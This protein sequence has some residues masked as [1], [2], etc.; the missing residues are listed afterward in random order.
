MV[1]SD[2]GGRAG[3]W[4]ELADRASP[5]TP[6]LRSWWLLHLQES[7]PLFVLVLDGDVL[8]GGVALRADRWLGARRLRMLGSGVLCGDHL[9][10]VHAAGQ[11]AVVVHHLGAWLAA[12]GPVLLD[13]A[14]L[15]ED[16][17]MAEAAGARSRP[18][19]VAP[20]GEV[21]GDLRG[22]YLAT[23]SRNLRR[24]AGR[25]KRR[26]E[27][28]GFVPET[29]APARRAETMADFERLHRD[30]ADRAPLLAER[31]ALERC[32]AAG[33]DAG[34]VRLDVLRRGAEAPVAVSIGFWVGGRLS[35]YQVA[36]SLAPEH[37][38]AGTVLILHVIEDAVRAGAVEIDLLR[39]AEVYKTRLVDDVRTL[40]RVR[41]ARGALPRLLL[42]LLTAAS[43]TRRRLVSA[44]R[45]APDHDAP[46]A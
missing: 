7:T 40:H 39:G 10:A 8:I 21:P 42:T 14:G 11:R 15:V 25:A 38:E 34:E 2:L 46:A 17:L 37:A 24:S 13:L 32:L 30:R 4:D 20:Y 19:D 29:V 9:D 26:L 23:R 3:A 1:G 22:D 5:P 35:L 43:A 18:Q 44:R 6:F 27:A 33:L 45:T 36:R 41:A 28:D 16:S 12:T 31:S